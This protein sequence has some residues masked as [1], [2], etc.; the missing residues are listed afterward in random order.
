MIEMPRKYSLS[1]A[2]EFYAR[3]IN[4]M[5]YFHS[6]LLFFFLLIES[7]E[8]GSRRVREWCAILFDGR[9]VANTVLNAF[10]YCLC[11]LIGN[12]VL[13]ESKKKKNSYLNKN[14]GPHENIPVCLAFLFRSVADR[15]NGWFLFQKFGK[16]Q[17]KHNKLVHKTKW[18]YSRIYGALMISCACVLICWVSNHKHPYIIIFV[19]KQDSLVASIEWTHG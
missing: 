18:A 2:C 10:V 14:V 9:L 1:N 12:R 5:V 6:N 19:Y 3:H 16:L 11:I 8:R 4:D 13:P 7:C 17:N 15:T